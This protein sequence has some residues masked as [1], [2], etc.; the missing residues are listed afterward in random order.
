MT[1]TINYGHKQTCIMQHKEQIHSP[2]LTYNKQK[3][4]KPQ[5]STSRIFPT[6]KFSCELGE[7]L[8]Q[9]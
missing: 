3:N 9:S 6:S 5:C 2:P 1:I 8:Y 4:S 7:V